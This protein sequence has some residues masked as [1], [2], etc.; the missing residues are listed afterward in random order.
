MKLYIHQ[1]GQSFKS[2]SALL[3]DVYTNFN[4]NIPTCS[5]KETNI[6]IENCHL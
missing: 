3:S 6:A 4:V 1:Y 2:T 5:L